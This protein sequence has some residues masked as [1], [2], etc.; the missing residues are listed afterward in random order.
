VILIFTQYFTPAKK[1]GGPITSITNMIEQLDIDFKVVARG[2]DLN[3]S[4]VLS[5]E[6]NQWTNNDS[7]WYVGFG[8]KSILSYIQEIRK[9]RKHTFYING[10]FDIMLNFLPI[11]FGKK[12]IVAPRGMLQNGAL[13][14][15]RIKKRIYLGLLHLVLK[16]KRVK[17]HATDL[18]E[19]MDITT[20]FGEQEIEA[21]SNLIAVQKGVKLNSS[22]KQDQLR[23]VYFSLI[24][25]KKNLLFLL[26]CM[27][28]SNADIY[29]DVVGPVK[30]I[31]YFERCMA[32]I[33]QH[34]KLL[35]KVCFKGPTEA[36]FMQVHAA[37]YDYFVLPTKGENFGHA[38]VESLANGLP[39]L[40]SEFTPWQFDDEAHSGL[41]SL[42][43][44]NEIWL[45]MLDEL[46]KQ[47]SDQQQ[48]AKIM[49]IEYYC[50]NVVSKNE[51]NKQS[52][53]QLF[54][55]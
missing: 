44:D 7:R 52:Y 11:V 10:L 38:I 36:N 39:V 37:E 14:N 26:E 40:I 27:A 34:P 22:K 5:V 3:E 41:Y 6:L 19:A 21:I 29:L 43:L 12:L 48:V 16:T 55:K 50:K 35:E 2:H 53:L 31:N 51:A 28:Q 15:G 24:A 46:V 30:D 13:Q 42:S 1:A 54:E 9:Q 45:S 8:T 49:A 20:I 17:W 18:V 47:D 25:E 32:F 33:D 4:K 23:L